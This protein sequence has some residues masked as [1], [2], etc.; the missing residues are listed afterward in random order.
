M[1][2][3]SDNESLNPVI[4]AT[5]KASSLPPS[6]AAN[7]VDDSPVIPPSVSCVGA[8]PVNWVAPTKPLSET[9]TWKRVLPGNG[10]P[11]TVATWLAYHR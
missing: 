6:T 3:K 2:L 4:K 1:F 7:R 8:V 9:K 11:D 5:V 10:N